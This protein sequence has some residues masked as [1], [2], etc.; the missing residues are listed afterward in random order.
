MALTKVIGAG[1]G[2]LDALAFSSGNG[3]DFSANLN[4]AGMSSE[5]LHDYE[6]GTFTPSYSQSSGDTLKVGRYTRVGNMVTL[7]IK[8]QVTQ[9]SSTTALGKITGFPFTIDG[10]LSHGSAV[11][12][13][14]S[15]T[16]DLHM[17]N[18]KGS[19][20]ETFNLTDFTNGSTFSSGNELGIGISIS[21]KIDGT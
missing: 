2:T 6:E 21:Y 1:V 4:N 20:T 17:A 10:T 15:T 18:L 8:M 3:V 12:R 14:F 19:D 7:F 11:F 13:E 9:T 16:G 5:V